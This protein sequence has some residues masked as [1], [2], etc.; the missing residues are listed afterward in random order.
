MAAA[1]KSL[2]PLDLPSLCKALSAR[3][4][5]LRAHAR[6]KTIDINSTYSGQT[7]GHLY[8]G[9]SHTS[10]EPTALQQMAL[11]SLPTLE[12]ARNQRD[13]CSKAPR[14]RCP[15]RY[16]R[17]HNECHRH[18]PQTKPFLAAFA[19]SA[20]RPCLIQGIR[21]SQ[22][23]GASCSYQ[24]HRCRIEQQRHLQPYR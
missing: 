6:Y 15:R 12:P 23:P 19:L 14:C 17:F 16:S 21:F 5:F 24:K 8:R 13:Y 18:Q 9:A 10:S 1:T 2:L 3:N 20:A 7:C 22:D 4:P 11:P